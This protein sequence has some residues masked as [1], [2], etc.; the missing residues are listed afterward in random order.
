[1]TAPVAADPRLHG[2]TKI[3]ARAVRR[4]VSAVTADAMEVSPSDVSVELD[5]AGGALSIVAKAPVRLTPLGRGG[6]SG[7]SL[8]ERLSTAQ[9]TISERV[10]TLTG[11]DVR[12]V[13]LRITGAELQQ[14][15]RVS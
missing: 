14:R 1:V 12:R 7:G 8:V 3:S 11:S 4:V 5:D 15:R 13:D 6:V 9:S 2:R 10:L